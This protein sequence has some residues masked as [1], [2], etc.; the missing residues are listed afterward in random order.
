ML[1]TPPPENAKHAVTFDLGGNT[2]VVGA[3]YHYQLIQFANA[4]RSYVGAIEVS[5]GIGFVPSICFFGCS[6]ATVTTHHSLL[7]LWGH[8]LQAELGYAG[9]LFSQRFI[10]ESVYAPGVITG[11]RY[12]PKTWLLRLYVAGW[13]Y[14]EN[15]TGITDSDDLVW[16]KTTY[17]LPSLGLSIGKRF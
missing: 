5:A 13:V 6:Q 9:T 8:K 3:S 7:L 4:Q 15:G 1:L 17:L 14:H 2:P 12:A 16:Q 10:G 11:L